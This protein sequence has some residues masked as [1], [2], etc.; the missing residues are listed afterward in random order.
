EAVGTPRREVVLPPETEHLDPLAVSV[1]A[2]LEASDEAV[3]EEDREHVP[4]EAPFRWLV[5]EVPDVVESEQGRKQP[6]V[7]DET[8]EGR[9]EGDGGR[10][11][12]RGRE[13]RNLVRQH[14]AVPANSLNLDGNERTAFDQLYAQ[15]RATRVTRPVGGRLRRAEEVEDVAAG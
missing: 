10:R 5:E 12:R 9:E 13:Q 2:R 7:P 15:R 4:A 6:S 1:D 3:A 8:V 14:V 11:L